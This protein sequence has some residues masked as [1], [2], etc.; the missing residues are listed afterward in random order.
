[1]N[2]FI[3]CKLDWLSVVDWDNVACRLYLASQDKVWIPRIGGNGYDQ[4]WSEESTGVLKFTSTDRVDM[5][6]L[7]TA[8]GKPLQKL[9]D[10]HGQAHTW[11]GAVISGL[12]GLRASR[13]DLALDIFDGGESAYDFA[14]QLDAGAVKST[15]RKW[16]VYKGSQGTPGITTYGGGKASLRRLRYYD[17]NAESGGQF[18]VSRIELQLR[19]RHASHVWD[20]CSALTSYPEFASFVLGSIAGCFTDAGIPKLNQIFAG[21]VG[22]SL[23]EKVVDSL[24][25]WEWLVRQVLPTF[26]QD[27]ADTGQHLLLRNFVRAIEDRTG[28]PLENPLT[29]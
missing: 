28:H 1:M 10:V 8:S 2:H 14:R 13:C 12:A 25:K 16:Y 22:Y 3:S 15:F 24:E 29:K 11:L 27:F 21:Q 9:A 4:C 6:T 18:P 17:K 20:V 19:G 7:Y 5:G 26:V 23:P